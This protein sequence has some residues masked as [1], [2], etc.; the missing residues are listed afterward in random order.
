MLSEFVGDDLKYM[1][2]GFAKIDLEVLTRQYEMYCH[3]WF[4]NKIVVR[5]LDMRKINRRQESKRTTKL[6]DVDSI[7]N[8]VDII[9]RNNW[10]RSKKSGRHDECEI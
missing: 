9:N 7:N 3:I 8:S 1:I 6:T 10:F 4:I 2:I 5:N